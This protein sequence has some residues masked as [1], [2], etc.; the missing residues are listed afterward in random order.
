MQH[1]KVKYWWKGG[2]FVFV[3]DNRNSCFVIGITVIEFRITCLGPW[4][5]T[6]YLKNDLEVFWDI[7]SISCL[8]WKTHYVHILYI[9]MYTDIED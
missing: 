9:Y 6:L 8:Q 4:L 7:T 2:F 3:F 1:D 5:Q